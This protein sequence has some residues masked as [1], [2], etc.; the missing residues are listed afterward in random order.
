[1]PHQA[2]VQGISGVQLKYDIGTKIA[3]TGAKNLGIP[4]ENK[5][6]GPLDLATCIAKKAFAHNFS[7]HRHLA[8]LQHFISLYQSLSIIVHCAFMWVFQE[9]RNSVYK[10]GRKGG[11][12]NP[13][14]QATEKCL[15]LP[16]IYGTKTTMREKQLFTVLHGN[17]QKG[18]HSELW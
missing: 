15:K 18:L 10:K 4:D 17:A 8:V 7:P 13:K 1:M 9:L 6:L 11:I 5:R 12:W 2:C 14:N 16:K 3:P